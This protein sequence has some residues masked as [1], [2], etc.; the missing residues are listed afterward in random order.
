MSLDPA[1]AEPVLDFT[2]GWRDKA[3]LEGL[4]PSENHVVCADILGRGADQLVFVGIVDARESVQFAI[5]LMEEKDAVTLYYA[6][7]RVLGT[8][9]LEG[10]VDVTD[11]M[12]AGDFLGRKHDQLLLLNT[13][14]NAGDG[15]EIVD[16][17]AGVT[18]P[19]LCVYSPQGAGFDLV[20]QI[21]ASG[22]LMVGDFA[23]IGSDQLFAT[24][25]VVGGAPTV[26]LAGMSAT[27]TSSPVIPIYSGSVS[28]FEGW[29][30]L[31]DRAVLGD[32]MGLGHK[33]L[34]LLNTS[35]DAGDGVMLVDFVRPTG[36][37]LRHYE[38]YADSGLRQAIRSPLDLVIAGDFFGQGRDQILIISRGQR[39]VDPALT[40]FALDGGGTF[41]I[42]YQCS[43]TET[44]MLDGWRN[45]ALAAVARRSAAPSR[46]ALLLN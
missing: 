27:D 25:R 43:W 19:E 21:L 33:Q 6:Q 1:A 20:N 7:P 15:L 32:F 31:D 9:P 22:V 36:W 38:A 11:K 46:L 12:V 44:G 17:S 40:M 34:A 2:S 16:F 39:N 30:D 28:L 26:Y 23:G 18:N 35:T 37:T 10:Y 5:F 24:T 14:T 41:A 42:V 29:F 45:C 8:A 13:S 4:L 3:I